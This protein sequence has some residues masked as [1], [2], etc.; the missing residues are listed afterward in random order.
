MAHEDNI[1]RVLQNMEAKAKKDAEAKMQSDLLNKIVEDAK[2]FFGQ[3]EEDTFNFD[4]DWIERI[5]T[6]YSEASE[7]TVTQ[8]MYKIKN[9]YER[10]KIQFQKN[11]REGLIR[12]LNDA[13]HDNHPMPLSDNFVQTIGNA[14]GIVDPD[15][16]IETYRGMLYR[17][18]EEGI[19]VSEDTSVNIG[20]KLAK[21]FGYYANA[22]EDSEQA[23]K[24]NEMLEEMKASLFRKQNEAYQRLMLDEAEEGES[25]EEEAERL[26]IEAEEA[27]NK[28]DTK[29]HGLHNKYFSEGYYNERLSDYFKSGNSLFEQEA[30]KWNKDNSKADHDLEL[31]RLREDARQKSMS[32]ILRAFGINVPDSIFEQDTKYIRASQ[33]IN[34]IRARAENENRDLTD[35]ENEEI[36]Q[37]EKI[38]AQ[39]E[40]AHS[41]LEI[42]PNNLQSI[43]NTGAGLITT[44]YLLDK[45]GQES[46]EA[47]KNM[48]NSFVVTGETNSDGR[49]IGNAQYKAEKNWEEFRRNISSQFE[50]FTGLLTVGNYFLS[51]IAA[52]ITSGNS[53][54]ADNVHSD[55]YG[56]Y[57]KR[58]ETVGLN[59]TDMNN[60]ISRFAAGFMNQGMGMESAVNMAV[61]LHNM[62]IT[63]D[64][65][66]SLSSGAAKEAMMQ[67][68]F[69]AALSGGAFSQYGINTSGNVLTGYL[70]GEGI[71]NVNVKLSDSLQS[72]YRLDLMEKQLDAT[73]RESMSKQIRDWEKLGMEIDASKGKLLS[74][75]KELVLGAVDSTIPYVGKPLVET[76]TGEQFGGLDYTK[77]EL[78]EI[79]DKMT[80][81]INSLDL[82]PEEKETLLRLIDSEAELAIAWYLDQLGMTPREIITALQAY[83][84]GKDAFEEWCRDHD[85][86]IQAS[87]A[88]TDVVYGNFVKIETIV[89]SI[90]Q[91]V[92]WLSSVFKE[93]AGVS[94]LSYLS[95]Y[96]DT[97]PITS[98]STVKRTANYSG[99]NGSLLFNKDGNAEGGYTDI[100]QITSIAEKGRG[101]LI[102]PLESP[103][104]VDL[105]A[106]A[107]GKAG[108]SGDIY[109]TVDFSGTNILDNEDS[110]VVIAERIRD[111]VARLDLRDGGLR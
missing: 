41:I 75:D 95:G 26:A 69:D 63:S 109:L 47:L 96:T 73:S 107:M 99:F 3:F 72:L 56:W 89:D 101:E 7:N 40:K 103:K 74:F 28:F 102:L 20:D 87:N 14:P 82:V 10:G 34:R 15:E 70:A 22:D 92:K 6:F 86:A 33:D 13:L 68:A 58:M 60:D 100:E 66:K 18:V 71:D 57:T 9:E 90:G 54:S 105:L 39:Y 35:K 49:F 8:A 38:M 52:G 37:K 19:D 55:M 97:A 98:K 108:G 80:D 106:N 29:S 25:P 4:E 21:Y 65:Y 24:F 76:L 43:I 51:S 45:A 64:T 78:T 83:H 2:E 59:T 46:V 67:S 91:K 42:L 111:E 5:T 84:Q 16:V 104:T 94:T 53:H 88:L 77:E 11:A 85:I 23:D 12:Q 61:R 62:V 27:K 17:H 44:L 79:Q 93:F 31:D 30:N 81:Y 48:N 1:K 50:A 110:M 32:K 36:K